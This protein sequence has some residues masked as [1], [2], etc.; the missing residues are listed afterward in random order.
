MHQTTDRKDPGSP[1]YS[2]LNLGEGFFL[3][4]ISYEATTKGQLKSAHPNGE[5]R[6]AATLK[7]PSL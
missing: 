5:V 3:L 2:D 1:S 4:K 6:T 7:V